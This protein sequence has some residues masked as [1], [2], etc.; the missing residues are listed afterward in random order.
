MTAYENF[1][2]TL[3][4]YLKLLELSRIKIQDAGSRDEDIVTPTAL[5]IR[6]AYV[7]TEFLD[8]L[9]EKPRSLIRLVG[10]VCEWNNLESHIN[11]IKD[12]QAARWEAFRPFARLCEKTE[13]HLAVRDIKPR[14]EWLDVVA[15]FNSLLTKEELEIKWIIAKTA[16]SANV[17]EFLKRTTTANE[18]KPATSTRRATTV[19]DRK[20]YA[21]YKNRY[22]VDPEYKRCKKDMSK[23]RG[24]RQFYSFFKDEH[25]ICD[26]IF[27]KTLGE[28]YPTFKDFERA[29]DAVRKNNKYNGRTDNNRELLSRGEPKVDHKW[30]S[31]IPSA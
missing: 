31:A 26:Q 15:R 17:C 6:Q 30:R 27:Q 14:R 10:R 23:K 20:V 16:K 12:I 18:Q 2:R 25:F 8:R 21:V 22:V 4:D 9:F 19:D 24:L 11:E 1:E 28:K 7:A 5:S 3:T 13:S 29:M